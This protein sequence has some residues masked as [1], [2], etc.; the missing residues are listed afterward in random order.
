MR[1]YYTEKPIVKYQNTKVNMSEVIRYLNEKKVDKEIKRSTYVIFRI[2][3]ANGSSGINNN[4][5]GC[6]TDSGRWGE[7]LDSLITGTVIKT[8]NA[9]GKQRLFAAFKDFKGSVDFLLNRVADRGLYVGGDTHKIVKM[10]I[11]SPVQLAKAYRIEWVTGDPNAVCSQEQIKNFL[12]MY[13]QA[14]VLFA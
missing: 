2:E 1:N 6:Q 12:S 10:H 13:K 11:D 8:E 5:V 4:Y 14:E 7:P 9:T 3:S